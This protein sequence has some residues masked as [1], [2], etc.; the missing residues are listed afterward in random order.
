MYGTLVAASHC[1][2]CTWALY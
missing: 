1:T 2:N